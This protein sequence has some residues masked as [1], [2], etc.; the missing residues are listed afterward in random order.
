[1]SV[2]EKYNRTASIY[3][4][5]Y[6]AIQREKYKIM[7]SG[8]KLKGR[9]LDHGCGTGLL[10]KFLGKNINGVD[11]SAEM[12]K[13]K[14][15]GDL[16]DVE[17]LPYK[18]GTFDFILSFTTLQN[19]SSQEKAIKEAKRVLKPK[20]TFVCTFLRSLEPKLKLLLEKHFKTLE[21]RPCGED[22][23]FILSRK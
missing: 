7:L 11:N 22:I 18:D 1:M 4:Q 23:G 14:G 10:S 19:C 8:L 21:K 16:A 15:S 5:R 2:R 3:N 20:G 13:I 17:K 12:L 6:R 9:I